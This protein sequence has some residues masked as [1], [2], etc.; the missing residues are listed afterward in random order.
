ME[1]TDVLTVLSSATLAILQGGEDAREAATARV[2][3]ASD[4]RRSDSKG[5]DDD[6]MDHAVDGDH[7]QHHPIAKRALPRH[8]IWID[9]R[10]GGYRAGRV[11]GA[12]TA[13]QRSQRKHRARIEGGC[14]FGQKDVRREASRH[15]SS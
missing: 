13:N 14:S 12:F 8:E 11:L 4:R 5:G 9:A 15:R 10:S 2:R 1:E 6:E 7:P 3:A